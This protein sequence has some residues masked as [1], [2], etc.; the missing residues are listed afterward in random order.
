MQINGSEF[1][2]PSDIF[3]KTCKRKASYLRYLNLILAL[4]VTLVL[5]NCKTAI[6]VSQLKPHVPPDST[7]VDPIEAPTSKN[8][9]KKPSKKL[10]GLIQE[11]AN[12]ITDDSIPDEIVTVTNT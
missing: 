3:T 9:D 4:I 6:A 5:L 11:P 2:R 8:S 10:N 7:T 12:F 1:R